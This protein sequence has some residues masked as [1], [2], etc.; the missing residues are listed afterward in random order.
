MDWATYW[1][2]DG[3]HTYIGNY[4]KKNTLPQSS[5]IKYGN[6]WRGLHTYWVIVRVHT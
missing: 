6:I 2:I 3:A 5:S 1:V 4:F